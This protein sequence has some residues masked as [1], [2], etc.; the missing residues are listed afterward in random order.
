MITLHWSSRFKRAFTHKSKHSPDV[1]EKIVNA[2]RL[3][4]NNPYDP[5]LKTHKLHGLF[6]GS[7]ACSVEYDIRIV[8]EFVINPITNQEEILLN[9]IGTH[10]EVY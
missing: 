2:L 10:E 7:L 5:M 9:D 8:F 6:K 3:L 1:R 4:E